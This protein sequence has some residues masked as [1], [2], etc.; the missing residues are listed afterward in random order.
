MSKSIEVAKE[1]IKKNCNPIEITY[2]GSGIWSY[3]FRNADAILFVSVPATIKTSACLGD[4]LGAAPN[5]S[6]S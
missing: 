1:A 4:A 2:L 6:T 3:A 5:L